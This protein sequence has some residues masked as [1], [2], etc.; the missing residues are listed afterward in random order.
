MPWGLLLIPRISS[1]IRESVRALRSFGGRARPICG[2]C[3]AVCHVAL[4]ERG[5][6]TPDRRRD[7]LR[8]LWSMNDARALSPLLRLYWAFRIGLSAL[9]KVPAANPTLSSGG[10]T[11]YAYPA[12]KSIV[13]QHRR[14]SPPHSSSPGK[15][16]ACYRAY[17]VQRENGGSGR[18]RWALESAEAITQSGGIGNQGREQYT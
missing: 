8:I 1:I 4:R 3:L 2:N 12:Q 13:G 14:A 9:R 17:E 11:R 18:G 5:L 10:A 7:C 15:F 16:A 6:R